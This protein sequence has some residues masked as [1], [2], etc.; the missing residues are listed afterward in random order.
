MLLTYSHVM[1]NKSVNHLANIKEM[2]SSVVYYHGSYTCW[3]NGLSVKRGLL[4]ETHLNTC[5]INIHSC[6]CI[7]V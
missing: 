1:F 5:G 7:D 2:T 4:L 6:V 3:L